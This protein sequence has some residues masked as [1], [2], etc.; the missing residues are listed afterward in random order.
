MDRIVAVLTL[1]LFSASLY[2]DPSDATVRLI[3]H[4]GSGTIIATGEGWTLILSCAHCFQGQ[5]RNKPVEVHMRHPAPGQRQKVGVTVL[6]VSGVQ[7]DVSLLRM[8]VGPVPFVSPV[9][10]IGYAPDGD[11]WSAGFDAMRMP[12]HCKPAKIVSQQ[13]PVY[14]TDARPN[15]GRSGG[16]LIEKRSGY[17]VG[18]VSAYSG[19]Q[20]N[21]QSDAGDYVP[22]HHG[23]Y[24]SLTTIQRFLSR[25]DPSQPAP[26][27]DQ[28]Y[29]QPAP[30]PQPYRLIEPRR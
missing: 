27:P 16:S 15:H 26:G 9:A 25:V 28:Q 13:G 10:P 12:V 7:D 11:C 1:L 18:V 29:R 4:G 24:A 22:G 6:A 8:N 2:A 17:L 20:R 23:I 30:G 19:P 5:N 3:S 14:L 21:S